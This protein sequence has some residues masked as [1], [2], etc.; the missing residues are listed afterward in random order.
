[1]E[2]IPLRQNL[3]E[4]RFAAG[5]PPASLDRLADIGEFRDFKAGTL[6]FREGSENGEYYLLVAGHVALEMFVPGRGQVRILTLGP[7]DL[8]AWSALIGGRMTTRALS[9]ASTR[10]IA[11]SADRLEKLCR[12]DYEFGY[13]WMRAVAV[14]LSQRL[15]ATRLQLLDLFGDS[16]SKENRSGVN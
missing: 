15:L 12:Q 7:G 1:M 14:A 2:S 4:F 3:S 5:L 16:S 13:H 9:L 8:L 6:L 10:L 11:V